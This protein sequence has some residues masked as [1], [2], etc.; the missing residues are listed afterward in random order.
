MIESVLDDFEP[1]DPVLAAGW[2]EV[3]LR[4]EKD[5]SLVLDT[6]CLDGL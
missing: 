1:V 4:I 5:L 2:L 6:M 3:H